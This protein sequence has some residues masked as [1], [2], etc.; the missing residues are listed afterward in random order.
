MT[1]NHTPAGQ[2]PLPEADIPT[3]VRVWGEAI[4]AF[5][6]VAAELSVDQW[7]AQT[8]CPGW[9]VADVVAH[10]IGLERELHG[11]PVPDHQPDWSTLPHVSG[12]I[13][14]YIEVAVDLRRGRS[15]T[16]LLA[17]LR[18]TIA[19]RR[20]D[21]AQVSTDPTELVAGPGG[22]EV[23]RSALLSRR[24]LDIWTHEQDIRV[25]VGIPGGLD[26]DAAWVT[27]DRLARE[28]PRVWGKVVGAPEG[29]R[30]FI[31]VTGPGVQ[32]A[33]T[34]LVGAHGRAAVT[35]NGE[36]GEWGSPSGQPVSAD[37]TLRCSFPAY[38]ALAAGREGIDAFVANGDLVIEGGDQLR[39][40]LIPAMAVTP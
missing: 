24:I 6:D 28:L 12:P 32:F 3:L 38:V 25:A 2:L 27:A 16:A 39:A 17:E 13:G 36:D 7:V 26:C 29:S 33:Q 31:D 22:I 19:L 40:Q 9:S 8:P 5:A 11:D 34:I 23:P 20:A 4:G 15:R 10:I 21:L 18:E 37:V 14:Q 1:A 35:G 30:F